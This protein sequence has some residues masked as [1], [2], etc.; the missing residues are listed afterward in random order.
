MS[1]LSEQTCYD[2]DRPSLRLAGPDPLGNI[3][4]FSCSLRVGLVPKFWDSRRGL[5]DGGMRRAP[6]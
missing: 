6:I 1:F 3:E 4:A 2:L 5:A